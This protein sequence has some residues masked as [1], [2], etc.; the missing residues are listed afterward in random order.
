MGSGNL[1]VCLAYV[2]CHHRTPRAKRLRAA[3]RCVTSGLVLHLRVELA[4]EQDDQRR[5]PQPDHEANASTKGAV[6]LV[7]VVEGGDVPRDLSGVHDRRI[8]TAINRAFK[9]AR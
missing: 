9:K 3:F 5:D 8:T 7:V 6:Y 2:I 4:A 1:D